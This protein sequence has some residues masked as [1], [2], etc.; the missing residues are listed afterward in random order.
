MS[1]LLEFDRLRVE[2][3]TPV[4]PRPLLRSVSLS[5]AAGEAVGLVGESGSGKSMTARSVLGMLPG[6]SVATGAV[7]FRGV[8]IGGL[9]PAGLRRL[10]SRDVAMV[11]QDPRASVNPVRTVGDFLT[12]VLR[13]RG[14][15][16]AAAREKAG[17]ILADIGVD[18][19][20]HRLKQR[21]YELSGGMLQRVVIAAA[22]AG[23]PALILA[24]E[25]T[26]ALDVTTQEEVVAILDE[27]RRQRGRR[28]CSSRTT[29]NW[30]RRSATGSRS[31]M[32]A[33]S[34]RSCRPRG[35]TRTRDTRTPK[36][37]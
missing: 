32:R 4:G 15:S 10:R 34:W 2:I 9:D 23:E 16:R 24:D 14:M 26:T 30:P 28:C 25:P 21:P 31:C 11:F 6:G 22:L 8:D 13:E 37:C 33:R 1:A 29:W 12:E 36:R 20:A 17:G 18:R 19:L 7:R 35:C 27:Q 5:V 3:P